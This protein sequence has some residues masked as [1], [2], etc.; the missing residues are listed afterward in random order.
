MNQK[1][2]EEIY[3]KMQRMSDSELQAT[4]EG[5]EPSSD[6]RKMA[7]DLIMPSLFTVMVVAEG[8]LPGAL[9]LFG[10]H[11]AA[12]SVR[13]G[14]DSAF[15]YLAGGFAA[16]VIG[17]GVYCSTGRRDEEN[18]IL[19]DAKEIIKERKEARFPASSGL[20]HS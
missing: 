16:G 13:A 3:A 5:L 4:V 9:R 1:K 11:E 12:E 7:W 10:Y 17:Y 6:S 15:G 14:W 2:R 20:A 18:K 8:I 19:Y